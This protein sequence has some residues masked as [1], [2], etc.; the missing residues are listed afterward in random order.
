[1]K[2]IKE[3]IENAE[4]KKTIAVTV[5]QFIGK[6]VEPEMFSKLA[7][8]FK[9]GRLNISMFSISVLISHIPK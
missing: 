1:M 7:C 4:A 5:S 2:H 9:Y 3:R 6:L 8:Y